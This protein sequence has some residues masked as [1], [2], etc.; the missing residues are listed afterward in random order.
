M[1]INIRNATLELVTT[2]SFH[3]YLSEINHLHHTSVMR[4]G[5]Y[6]ASKCTRIHALFWWERIFGLIQK[7][8]IFNYRTYSKVESW[9][10][11]IETPGCLNVWC[12]PSKDHHSSV[13]AIAQSSSAH[14]PIDFTYLDGDQ[15]SSYPSTY[16]TLSRTVSV[17][18]AGCDGEWERHVWV[19]LHNI[20]EKR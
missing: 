4:T 8:W 11:D 16:I 18:R 20:L 10:F 2:T 13:R 15:L 5:Q 9:E 7:T 17:H 3:F 6:S 12:F 1:L 14:D 19:G